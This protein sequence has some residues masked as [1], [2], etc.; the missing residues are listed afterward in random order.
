[1]LA[2]P[3][4][5]N[6]GSRPTRGDAWEIYGVDPVPPQWAPRERG[7]GR[8]LGPTLT[9]IIPVPSHF[10]PNGLWRSGEVIRKSRLAG[11]FSM[12]RAGAHTN[13]GRA[14]GPP[15]GPSVGLL[16]SVVRFPRAPWRSIGSANDEKIPSR[17]FTRGFGSAPLRR[18]RPPPGGLVV[19]FSNN[20]AGLPRWRTTIPSPSPSRRRQIGQRCDQPDG[21]S[22]EWRP[23]RVHLT[24][25]WGRDE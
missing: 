5:T 6:D 22:E 25:A 14:A 9:E 10:P 2:E 7:Q 11:A 13:R 12:A 17:S 4:P 1:M 8:C 21:T 16:R 15:Q 3:K 20:T 23:S 19:D 18:S 24:R